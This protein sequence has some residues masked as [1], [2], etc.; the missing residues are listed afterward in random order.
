MT[1]TIRPHGP[2]L[3]PRVT[4]LVRPSGVVQLG[5][6]PEG[7][8]LLHPAEL[9]ADTVLAF[10]RLLD[11]HQTRPQLI[12][13]AGERGITPERALALLTEIDNA[14]LLMHPDDTGPVRAVRVHGLGPLADAVS[15]GLRGIGLRPSRSRDY[16]PDASVTGWRA[17]LVVLTD[18]LVIDPRLANDLVLH[19]IPHLQVRIRDG[20]GLIGPFVLPG[21][22]SCLRC[23]DLTRTDYDADWPHLAAQLLDRV[24]HAAPAA[25]A[26]TAGLALNEIES[27]RACSADRTPATLNATLELDHESHLVEQRYWAAHA[28]CGCR[29]ISGSSNA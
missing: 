11:G 20:K 9:D 27:I 10:L 21:A 7:A 6:D 22:T 12:W 15:A 19:R 28:A 29:V 24:G 4:I 18:S 26:A 25:I 5:W 14:G 13:R 1:I 16:D 8:L 17:D 23:L 3:H 2:M